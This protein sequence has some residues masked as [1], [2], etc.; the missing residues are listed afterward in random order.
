MEGMGNCEKPLEEVAFA[1]SLVGCGDDIP[2][3]EKN[4]SKFLEA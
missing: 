4:R 1:M 2:G 3:R